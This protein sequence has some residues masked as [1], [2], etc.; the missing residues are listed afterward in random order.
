M[1]SLLSVVFTFVLMVAGTVLAQTPQ[2]PD[3]TYQGRLQQSGVPSDGLFDFSFQLYDSAV[4]GLQIGDTV[5]E[6]QF[7]V[8]DGLFTVSL[9]FPG[10][11]TGEQ[12]WLQITVNGETLNSLPGIWTIS[13][14]RPASGR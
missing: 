7:P 9:T 13:C 5:L 12:R 1:K 3:F 2:L 14:R 8:S 6:P 10:A 11:F 4:G